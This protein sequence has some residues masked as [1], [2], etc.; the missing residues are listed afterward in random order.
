MLEVCAPSAFIDPLASELYHLPN[1]KWF[2]GYHKEIKEK[3]FR[4]IRFLDDQLFSYYFVRKIDDTFPFFPEKRDILVNAAGIFLPSLNA[5][6]SFDFK[7]KSRAEKT[8]SQSLDKHNKMEIQSLAVGHKESSL[9]LLIPSGISPKPESI[10]IER[11]EK[12]NY[13]IAACKA[14]EFLYKI[15]NEPSGPKDNINLKI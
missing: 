12:V 5:E 3:K 4:R 6:L 10:K 14:L 8:T 9:A 13:P 7:M 1:G 11:P 2:G 15:K